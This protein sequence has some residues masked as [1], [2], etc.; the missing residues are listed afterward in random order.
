MKEGFRLYCDHVWSDSANMARNP[1]V[2]MC[3]DS[4][5]GIHSVFP[6][7]TPPIS[8]CLCLSLSIPLSCLFSLSLRVCVWPHPG[9]I[10]SLSA[11]RFQDS[12]G[13]AHTLIT[14]CVHVCVCVSVLVCALVCCVD[15]AVCPGVS[16]TLTILKPDDAP[17]GLQ[18]L[19]K[20][21]G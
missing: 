18:V 5:S 7:L 8:L 17:G 15:D 9:I 13:P 1:F 6:S 4:V 14:V 20:V 12:C 3:P 11:L 21:G 10:Q 16:G 2:F 19:P